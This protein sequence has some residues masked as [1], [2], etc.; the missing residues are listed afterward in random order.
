MKKKVIYALFDDGNQSVKKTL[1][2]LGYEVYSFGV[3]KKETVIECDLTNLQSFFEIAKDLPEPDFIFANPPCETFSNAQLATYEKGGVGNMYY[4]LDGT[5]ITDFEDWKTTT[6][7]NIKRMKRDKKQYFE[8]LKLKR[9]ISESLHKN[10]DEIVKHYQVPF[11][12]ENPRTSYC[13]K[14]FHK[15]FQKSNATYNSYDQSFSKKPTTFANNFGLVLKN[16]NVKSK[17]NTTKDIR[18][19]NKRSA[20]PSELI[21]HIIE[22][23]ESVTQF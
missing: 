9:E 4:Y 11:V 20:V 7:A 13:W 5:P 22:Q 14:I 17:V 23:M 18:N 21:I 2:P 12:I 16:E 10:T 3:Q 19:Y 6:S 8:Q 1:E 15:S